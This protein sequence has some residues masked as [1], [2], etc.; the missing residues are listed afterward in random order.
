MAEAEYH[1]RTSSHKSAAAGQGPPAKVLEGTNAQLRARGRTPASQPHKRAAAGQ[2]AHAKLLERERAQLHALLLGHDTL[3][4]HEDP[5]R[6]GGAALEP[7]EDAGVLRGRVFDE[8][9]PA[10]VV[11]DELLHDAPLEARTVA[12][13]AF[14]V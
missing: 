9:T 6:V 5:R 3:P 13:V 8:L 7:L 4:A 1:G 12:C 11:A 10:A 2:G 14:V